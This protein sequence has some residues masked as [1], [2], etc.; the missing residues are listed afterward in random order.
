[1]SQKS[2]VITKLFSVYEI[3]QIT[4]WLLTGVQPKEDVLHGRIQSKIP[5]KNPSQGCISTVHFFTPT[6]DPMLSRLWFYELTI[7]QPQCSY[8]C[9]CWWARPSWYVPWSTVRLRAIR[10]IYVYQCSSCGVFGLLG[11]LF[12]PTLKYPNYLR[13]LILRYSP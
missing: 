11:T 9:Y 7:T 12:W 5:T 8:R 6:K 10:T 13:T 2:K 1:M 4:G 3:K